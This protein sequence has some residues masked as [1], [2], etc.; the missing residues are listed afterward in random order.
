MSVNFRWEIAE[1]IGMDVKEEK[2]K[3]NKQ[4]NKML[5]IVWRHT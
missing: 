1:F 3:T 4:T 5:S 2:N